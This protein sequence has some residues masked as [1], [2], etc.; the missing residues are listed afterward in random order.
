[1]NVYYQDDHVQ[2]WHGDCR[3][4]TEWLAADALVTD[5]PYG[6]RWQ[7]GKGK[8]NGP[9]GQPGIIGDQ[10][11]SLRDDMLQRWGAERH[12]VVF[13]SPLASR[14]LGCRQ[15][16]AWHKPD[17]SGVFGAMGG[18]RR[19]WEEIFLVGPWRT[20][21]ATRSGVIKTN[22]G[23][24]EYTQGLHPHGKPV[25]LLEHLVAACPPGVIADPFA[26]AGSTLIA[27]KLQGR[28]VIGVEIEERYCEIAARRL[29]QDALPGGEAS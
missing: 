1:M 4:I 25:H 10:D 26:G 28:R 11:T 19:D 8:S 5:P 29:A 13:G 17:N 23:L 20:A 14:P 7:G 24:W 15:V 3:E 16:L 21:P 2:L 22:G 9:Q 12:G 18:W 6:I 27:A